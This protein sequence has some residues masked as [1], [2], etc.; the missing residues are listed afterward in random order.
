MT[1]K[2]ALLQGQRL[3]EDAV[4]VSPRLTAEVLLAHAT[5]RDREWLYAHSTDELIELWW[6]HYGRYLHQRIEGRPTQYIIGKQEFYSR[7]FRVTPDVLIP[8]PETEHVIEAALACGG[9]TI[10]D[11]GTGSGII[12]ITLALETKAR[13]T[14][15]DISP[16]ALRIAEDNARRLGAQVEFIECDLIPANRT[17]DLIVS[18][19]PYVALKD[20]DTLQREVRDHEPELALYGGHDGFEIYRCLIPAASAALNPNGFLVMEIGADQSDTVGAMLASWTSVEFR[21]DLAGIPR[22]A[23]ARKP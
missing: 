12:A 4:V 17:F 22:V 15:T 2:E 13:V 8:R 10:L 6:I 23:V 9:E 11:V 1:L 18:N 5:N 21:K 7:E 20:K 16:A 3:L 14:A 19:P